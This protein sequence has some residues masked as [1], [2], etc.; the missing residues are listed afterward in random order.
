MK[1]LL[2][3]LL[4]VCLTSGQTFTSTAPAWVRD[5]TFQAGSSNLIFVAPVQAPNNQGYAVTFVNTTA[6]SPPIFTFGIKTYR[7]IIF[8]MQRT[9][10]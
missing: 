7:G 6:T 1:V 4:L 9:T 3:V 5:F 8:W 2:S 10:T